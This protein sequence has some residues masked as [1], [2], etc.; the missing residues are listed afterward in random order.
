MATLIEL[1]YRSALV[2]GAGSGLGAAFAEA[3]IG[4]GLQV[5]G[6]SRQ[7]DRLTAREGFVPVEMDLA[8]GDGIDRLWDRLAAG[9][10]GVDVV[11][12]NAGYGVWGEYSGRSFADWSGQIDAMLTGTA[13]LLHRALPDLRRRAP[14]AIVVITSLA[15]DFPLPGLAGYNAVKAGLSGL[16]RGLMV[17]SDG[18]GP[19][20]VDF[21]PGD[22]R[23]SFNRA[24]NLPAILADPSSPLT[25]AGQ[26]L[27]ALM[28]GAPDPRRAAR[29]LVRALR[30][31]RHA[32]IRSGSFFQA[33]VAPTLA[34]LVPGGWLRVA[35]R[36][37]FG[38]H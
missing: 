18:R 11:V 21:R 38:I 10:P 36:R 6:T 8:D 34:R 17:E 13:R 4:Q 31:R 7:P 12:A 14:S 3:L 37:Y 30:R 25:G 19:T 16:A 23:T 35:S 1:G 33:R 5:W 32:V 2:T 29:D 27:N 22:F 26:R 9:D 20:I 28:E 15:V 24:M